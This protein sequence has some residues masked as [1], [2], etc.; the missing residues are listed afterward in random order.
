VSVY[1]GQL[2]KAY[3]GMATAT[4]RNSLPENRAQYIEGFV[5]ARQGVMALA[6][7][8]KRV[9][10]VLGIT[11]QGTAIWLSSDGQLDKLLLFSGTTVYSTPLFNTYAYDERA[12]GQHSILTI[13]S[14]TNLGVTLGTNASAGVTSVQFGTELIISIGGGTMYRYYCTEPGNVEKLFALGMATGGAPTL[15]AT[16]GG[17]M[18][19]S[20]EYS[21]LWTI[22]DELGREGSP[23]DSTSVTLSSTQN[24]VTVTRGSG[25]SGGTTGFTS[26]NVYRLNPGSET[27][28]FVATVALA[29]TT[30]TDTDS[31]ATVAANDAAPDAGEN[32]APNAGAIMEVWKNRLVLNDTSL[33]GWIQISNAGSSTQFS[34][35]A[36]PTNVDD[37]IRI[38]VGGKGD[39]EVTGLANLGSLLCVFKRQTTSLL[40]G[41]NITDF[42]MRPALEQGC[43]N[44]GSV[45]RC[46][47]V[48]LFLS[49]DGVY[50]IGYESGYAIQKVSEQ[51]DNL[52]AGFVRTAQRGEPTPIGRTKSVQV[53]NAI[54]GNVKSFYSENRYYLSFGNRTLCY[55]LETNG[56]TDTGWGLIKTVS[57]YLSQTTLVAGAAPETVFLT[58]GDVNN[59]A[60]FLYYYT[61]DDTPKDID[62]PQVIES[63]IVTRCFDGD[64]PVLNRTKRAKRFTQ[65]GSCGK[66][67]GTRIG[68]VRGYADGRLIEVWPI[69]AEMVI[70]QYGA[71]FEQ[72]WTP[73]MTGH[74]LWA[75]VEFTVNDLTL[76]DSKMTY[77][78]LN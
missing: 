76:E 14:L 29:S 57:R 31:D 78:F 53:L 18:T 11:V 74:E 2:L 55:D 37:G 67:A 8:L 12:D 17:S 48:V 32:D 66:V 35:L 26:W 46:G 5:P 51:I 6:P 59:F 4:S 60:A 70:D 7:F 24:A 50:S 13:G 19:P 77:V 49:N 23:S 71:L 56:W 65:W 28:N 61:V 52:F 63:R 62:A 25:T 38:E 39:N 54:D 33:P 40:Y 9:Q 58:I 73:A 68:Q 75:E 3:T 27:F 34:S 30:Y 45:Q 41:D 20:Q 22:V 47:N 1:N 36:L 16:T 69:Y 10:K 64:G 44:F 43:Q 15:S 72:E 42:T 21:Y